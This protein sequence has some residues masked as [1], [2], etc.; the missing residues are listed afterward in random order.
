MAVLTPPERVA[1]IAHELSHGANGDPL[2]GQFLFGAVETVSTWATA[3]RPTAIG[4]MG[5]GLPVGPLV[6]LLGIPLELLMLLGSELLFLAARAF[7]LLV[8]R[9]SQRAEYL[10]DLLAATV[11]GSSEMQ[12]ALEKTYLFDV[13]DTAIRR[14]ALTTPKQPIGRGLLDA[15][16]ALPSSVLEKHREDSRAQHWQVDSTHPPTALRVAMLAALPPHRPSG[17]LSAQE[18]AALDA[19]VS[20]LVAKTQRELINRQLETIHG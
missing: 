6:S 13:V 15:V 4:R 18:L 16:E 11:A 9:E 14:H 12:S 20:R 3:L 10:A 17:L 7:L 5:D 19:E 2:R 8:L 1:V